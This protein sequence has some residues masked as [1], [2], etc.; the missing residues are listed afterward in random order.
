MFYRIA[1]VQNEKE[2]FKYDCADWSNL[3]KD[4]AYFSFY[5]LTYFDEHNIGCLVET[6]MD[7]DAV[8]FATN[9]LNSAIIYDAL[10]ENTSLLEKYIS[11]GHGCYIG[12][13]SKNKSHEFLPDKYKIEQIERDFPGG[14]SEMDGKLETIRHPLTE[15]HCVVNLGKYVSTAM[16]HTTIAGLYFDY[17]AFGD[18]H[19]SV[20][21]KI[22][23][24][25]AYNRVLM[26]CTKM[27]MGARL[28]VSTLPV[29]WQRQT[30]FFINIV[31][32]C[33]E[34]EPIIKIVSRESEI[35]NDFSK[36]YLSR[37]LNLY[38]R[39]FRFD[40]VKDL[41][42]ID[43]S[44][45]RYETVIFDSSWR[46]DEVDSF[47]ERHLKQIY[48]KNIRILHYYNYKSSRN[49]IYK[50]TVHS[51]FQQVDLLEESLLIAIEGRTPGA[52]GN[53]SYDS[54][55]LT[56][57]EAVKLLQ[58]N[59]IFNDTLYQKIVDQGKK[60]L[61]NDGSYDAMFVA[62][63]NFYAVW[64]MCDKNAMSDPKFIAL[65]DYIY[66]ELFGEKLN[67]I[68]PSEK[69][70]VL[71]FLSSVELVD[72]EKKGLL[73]SSLVQ[74][75]TMANRD[76][77]FSYAISSCWNIFAENIELVLSQKILSVTQLSLLIKNLLSLLGDLKIDCKIVILSNYIL[78][79]SNLIQKKIVVEDSE[80]RI[81]YKLLFSSISQI[82]DRRDGLLWNDDIY[83]SCYAIKALKKFSELST[84][85]IDEILT[86]TQPNNT[87]LAFERNVTK[88]DSSLI[89]DSTN[90][91]TNEL[92]QTRA[93]L[94]AAQVKIDEQKT[95]IEHLEAEKKELTEKYTTIEDQLKSCKKENRIKRVIDI[96][97]RLS[98][99]G[100]VFLI[101]QMIY[102]AVNYRD[103]FN[104]Y[105]QSFNSFFSWLMVGIGA[106]ISII[107]FLGFFRR[108]K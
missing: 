32:F 59:K 85:P 91:Q 99:I 106:L 44:E 64:K 1:I 102:V 9:A 40:A 79:L 28:V 38:K 96:I 20:F 103:S 63:A 22:V 15:A 54:S 53:Y 77:I 19:N 80:Q 74:P 108:K 10:C 75:L 45:C 25:S 100:L 52:K 94:S 61:L 58:E 107:T 83:S 16:H 33:T 60:R 95:N 27:A 43:L 48:D 34:G 35:D 72:D 3:F 23:V 81:L 41:G 66:R 11:M 42:G 98:I 36:E 101:V 24:D 62:S 84:Y 39:P 50:L 6:L 68:S 14:E 90:Q 104:A 46:D 67:N 97:G 21:D 70:Q 12:Y 49:P 86:L 76:D 73:L 87:L 93:E 18:K 57:F 37:Q 69:A 17:L 30:E 4:N 8:F 55:L 88:F 82:Y 2:V 78:V 51:A 7:F 31:K 56:T 92:V 47:C 29:D 71:Y 105:F 5:K 65:H 26:V 13:S 89:L